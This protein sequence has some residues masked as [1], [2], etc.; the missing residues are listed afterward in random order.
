MP[1][2]IL[3]RQALIARKRPRRED[4]R[5]PYF[6]DQTAMIHCTPF[7]RLKHKTQVFFAP[8]NDHVCTRI[9]HVLHVATIAAT[10]CRGLAAQ[11]WPMDSELAY[12][13]GLGHDLG[14]APF[15]H[16]GERTLSALLGGQCAFQHEIH[17]L[18][19]VDFLA[20]DGEGLNLTRGVRDAIICHNGE[21]FEQTL[22][23][24][25]TPRLPEEKRDKN[26]LP[27]TWEGCAVRFAD[28]IAYLGRDLEDALLAGF[29]TIADVP[30][31]IR[32]VLG[33]NN[34]EIINTLVIDLIENSAKSGVMGFSDEKFALLTQLRNFN[35]EHIYGHPRIRRY[36]AY[37]DR[38]I[39]TLFDHLLAQCERDPDEPG[40]PLDVSFARFL[41]R[42][43]PA[44]E[45]EKSGPMHWV[46]DYVAGM[47]DNYALAAMAQITLPEPISFPGMRGD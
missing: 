4:V 26:R 47:T 25:K 5:G 46:A 39:R 44:Y 30:P 21:L 29:V 18:R 12:A 24:E 32:A 43:R 22:A 14:H 13:G 20:R 2:E 16:S 1:Y 23:P 27:A 11:G 33:S 19:V 34:G 41:S 45:R 10:L 6:R 9:E 35:Y 8:E 7:R 17:S 40:L 28:K 37:C 36:E 42:M 15:G 38:I 3:D 31:D